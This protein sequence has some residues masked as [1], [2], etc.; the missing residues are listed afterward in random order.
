VALTGKRR[1][2]YGISVGTSVGK[3]KF[4]RIRR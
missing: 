2:A 4:G 3:Y 1:N